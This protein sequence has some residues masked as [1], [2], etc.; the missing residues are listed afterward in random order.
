[1]RRIHPFPVHAFHPRVALVPAALA[2]AALLLVTPRAQAAPEPNRWEEAITAF[3]DQDRE[4]PPARDGVL[5]VGSSSIRLWDL[6]ASF[7]GLNAI[8]R[9]FGGSVIADS[10]HF[11]DRI[12]LPHAPRQIVL[13]AGD[14]DIARGDSPEEVVENFAAFARRV[15]NALP[16]TSLLFIAIKPSLSR[17]ELWPEM[18][19]AN[20]K[21]EAMAQADEG[22]TF[23]DIAT[24]M[25]DESGRPRPELL[26]RDGLH[27]SDEGY[28]LWTAILAPHLDAPPRPAPTE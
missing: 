23:V 4:A 3:E 11:F 18:K 20:A 13:Y 21:I 5:F 28:A 8:N 7:E 10:L 17:W 25:L 24:P 1:M 12:V 15:S 6:A 26:A 9:G 27:L 16:G 14:N 22:I 2:L 19:E